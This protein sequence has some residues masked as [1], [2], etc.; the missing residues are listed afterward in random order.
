MR[1]RS[2]PIAAGGVVAD[3]VMTATYDAADRMTSVSFPDTSETCA[4]SYDDNGSQFTDF[5]GRP[6]PINRDVLHRNQGHPM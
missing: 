5:C 6:G 4:L 2:H 1:V 3:T